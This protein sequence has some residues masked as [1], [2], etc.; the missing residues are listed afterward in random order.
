MPAFNSGFY[1][2][3][4]KAAALAVVL[5]GSYAAVPDIKHDEGR[6]LKRYYD[7]AGIATDCDGNTVDVIAADK[8]RTHEEC[9]KITAAHAL[10]FGHNVADHLQVPISQKTFESHVNL[11]YNIGKEAYNNSTTLRKT[12]AGDI[13]G[14][15]EAMMKFIC[16]KPKPNDP[17]PRVTDPT[18]PCYSKN[19]DKAVSQGLKNRRERNMK[20]CLAGIE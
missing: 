4:G 5:A 17:N 16:Y 7:I 13:A 14:G 8:T 20:K 1:K 19:K 15:C 10:E 18:K 12:N 2:H 6:V 3:L 11:S 9:D